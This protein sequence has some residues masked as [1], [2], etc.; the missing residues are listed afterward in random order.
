MNPHLGFFS[1]HGAQ[2]IIQEFVPSEKEEM[3]LEHPFGRGMNF[4]IETADLSGL[5]KS[6]EKNNYPLTR[7]IKESWRNVG[8]K[9]K[10]FGSQE[11][12]VNEERLGRKKCIRLTIFYLFLIVKSK[13]DA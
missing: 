4:E 10:L 9:D 5:I 7:G 6:L 2:L 12:L 13:T 3:K 8:I 11:I 1:Y